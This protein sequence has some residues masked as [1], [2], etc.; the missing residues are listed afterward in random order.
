MKVTGKIENILQTQTGTTK[1]GKEWKKTSFVV[2]TDDEYNN[3]YCFDVF[4]EE[5]V[6]KFLQY[7][8]KGDV[9]D[10]DF[11]VKTNE[12]KGKYFTSLDAWKVFKADNSKQ[13]EEVAVEEEGDLP[14]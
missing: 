10:V 7:N 3:L 2:K 12:W 14:F 13:K 9:V 11:N 4:G 8:S 5:K 6:D 1:A